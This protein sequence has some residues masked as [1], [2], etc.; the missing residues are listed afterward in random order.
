MTLPHTL[1]AILADLV[2]VPS[3]PGTPNAAITDAICTHLDRPG[4]TLHR[5]P[6][7]G[8]ALEPAGDHR[9]MSRDVQI[10]CQGVPNLI[11]RLPALIA[12]PLA[13]IVGAPSD[14]AL[15][16]RPK[17][18][19]TLEVPLTGP[20]GHCLDPTRGV[21]A[22][23][24]VARAAALTG[25]AVVPA[26]SYRPGAGPHRAASRRPRHLGCG[27]VAVPA[28]YAGR[29]RPDLRG[30]LA[31]QD[32]AAPIPGPVEIAAHAEHICQQVGGQDLIR[33]ALGDDAPALQHQQPVA[34]LRGVVQV[35]QRHDAGQAKP[36]DQVQQ[37]QLMLD[38]Q[39][40]GG[41]V[42]EQFPGFLGQ[43]AGDLDALA[44]AA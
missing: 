8:W 5:I 16:A 18:K 9:A 15:S 1:P 33:G 38:V 44:F 20:P 43:G 25:R 3:L 37:L 31:E 14:M 29:D 41:F 40:V 30:G 22:L 11:A 7:P 27:I 24:P 12:Q 28:R 4:V 19:E 39:V 21:N 36:R 32:V 26:V 13:C 42:Q 2:A 35:V 34:E 17:G 6:T 10:G 23:Y